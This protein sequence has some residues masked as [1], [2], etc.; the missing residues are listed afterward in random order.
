MPVSLSSKQV[1]HKTRCD[2]IALKVICVELTRLFRC[3][4]VT[5]IRLFIVAYP[6][7]EDITPTSAYEK[8]SPKE[9]PTCLY[10]HLSGLC[11]CQ[12]NKNSYN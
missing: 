1:P 4:G 11:V 3:G 10:V 12:V 8:L 6:R 2:R 9:Q 7:R 5:I